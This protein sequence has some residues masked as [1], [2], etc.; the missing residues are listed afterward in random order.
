MT[1]EQIAALGPAFTNFLSSFRKCFP[2]LP[3]FKHLGTYCRGLLSDLTRKSVEP[4]A[5]A[6]GT[7]VRTLQEFLT[8]H[9]W[10]HG[11][12]REQIHRRVVRDHLPAPGA[13]PQGG[14]GTV[15]WIDET[16]VAK[17][18][19][20]TPGVQRQHCGAS[21]KIDN[22][23]VTVHLAVSHGRFMTMLD[24]ELFLPE[25][26]WD[27]HRDRC[28]EAHIPDS[29]IYR[30]KSTIALEQIQRAVANGVRF[31]WLTFDE[32][33]GSKPAFLAGLETLGLLYVCEVPKSLPCYPSLPKYRS[34]QKPFQP[35]RADSAVIRSKPFR[36]KKWRKMSLQRKTL[37]P[38]VWEVKAE[39]VHLA[40][41]GQ[42]TERTYWLIVARNVQSGELKYFISNAP[43]RT[44][45]A[46]L[47][48]VAFTRAGVEHV[49]RL[50]KTEIGFAHFEG[51]SYKGLI[52]HMILCQLVMLFV[53]EQT[54]QLRGEKS[55]ADN[56]ADGWGLE[57]AVPTLDGASLQTGPHRAS[58]VGHSVSSETQ[59]GRKRF[60]PAASSQARIAL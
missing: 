46:T 2:R 52:R 34:L 15:G 31:D 14:V 42:P 21:G 33:Y 9:A 39:Q 44:A 12:M 45:L 58:R 8:H 48:K 55:R 19:D 16:S 25:G 23:I 18:G 10:D 20:K 32:W 35:K 3:T 24:S 51:R 27:Q 36:G 57:P 1:E 5:L 26:T 60:T 17:K 40:R 56:G 11:R 59:Q 30:P 6:A 38:Q 54:T 49:F 43:P 37:G 53:A 29:V 41:D 13:G 22:C 4:I 7:A 47:M 50:A 28:R